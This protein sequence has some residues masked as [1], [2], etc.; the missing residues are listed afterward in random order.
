LATDVL[1]VHDA[2]IQAMCGLAWIQGLWKFGM[3]WIS[4]GDVRQQ[5]TNDGIQARVSN[6]CTVHASIGIMRSMLSFSNFFY[7]F[8]YCVLRPSWLI[9]LHIHSMHAIVTACLMRVFFRKVFHAWFMQL[10]VDVTLPHQ[11]EKQPGCSQF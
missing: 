10:L 8:M 7:A 3:C 9:L 6:S 11:P 5:L 4:K 2:V 1:Q